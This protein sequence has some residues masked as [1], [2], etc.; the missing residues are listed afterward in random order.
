MDLVS[1]GQQR[2]HSQEGKESYILELK[3]DPCKVSEE[4]ST[5][6]D[7]LIQDQSLHIRFPN[8][9]WGPSDKF[10][11][12]HDK[13]NGKEGWRRPYFYVHVSSTTWPSIPH[14]RSVQEILPTFYRPRST[15]LSLQS[16]REFIEGGCTLPLYK[17]KGVQ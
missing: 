6:T 13:K 8:V 10:S 14:E 4:T 7:T 2:D 9:P 12:S 11:D 16:G 1:N 15:V 17:K 3:I 5:H